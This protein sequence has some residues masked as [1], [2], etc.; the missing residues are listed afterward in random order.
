MIK[1]ESYNFFYNPLKLFE[2]QLDEIIVLFENDNI[3]VIGC[4]PAQSKITEEMASQSD[5][6][7]FLEEMGQF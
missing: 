1:Y 5:Y 6:L 3:N 2:K 4:F 7:L